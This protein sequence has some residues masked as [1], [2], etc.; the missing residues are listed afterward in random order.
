[1]WVVLYSETVIIG[2]SQLR[3]YKLDFHYNKKKTNQG[4]NAETEELTESSCGAEGLVLKRTES[5]AMK[6]REKIAETKIRNEKKLRRLNPPRP[7]PRPPLTATAIGSK[8]YLGCEQELRRG[9]GS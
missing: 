4:E 9:C 2:R 3:K 5:V 8:I 7:D 6:R 1:M